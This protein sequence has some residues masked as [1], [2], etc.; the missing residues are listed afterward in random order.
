MD[1]GPFLVDARAIGTNPKGVG[2]VLTEVSRQLIRL[3]PDQYHFL[4]T[5]QG[6]PALRE[7]G[8]TR[9]HVLPRLPTSAWEQLVLPAAATAI[10]AAATYSHGECGAL[11][12]PPLLL[13]LTEDPAVRWA[14]DPP[15]HLR[16]RARRLYSRGFMKPSLK[17]AS[18]AVSTSSVR[19]QVS[20]RHG[21]S[22]DEIRVIP[23]GVD[24]NRFHPRDVSA[25]ER[26]FFH[27]ASGDPRDRTE[28]L[29]DA[30]AQLARLHADAPEL[31]V[32]GDLGAHG[33]RI[34]SHASRAAPGK[35]RFTGR[36]TDDDLSAAYGSCVAYVQLSSDEGFG[37]QPLEALASGATLIAAPEPSVQEVVGGAVALWVDP[38]V[39]Q[40]TE[41]LRRALDGS[42]GA[43][44][45][46]V[47][48]KRAE[49]FSW[50][51]T[52]LAIDGL[53]RSL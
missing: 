13:H 40:V 37:L 33:H 43:R 28:L 44:A 26:F 45:R 8:A 23:L 22:A 38:N 5:T 47:N 2:R 31:A 34:M 46:D 12:G 15:S 4:C 7:M 29:L 10:K 48:P 9:R 16:E 53:L 21:L 27:L 25:D 20:E 50:E 30:Y 3:D 41:A 35:V 32:G 11:W 42:I 39:E 19:Q 1:S 24:T 52:A 6:D 49:R 14:R 51:R 18:L 36:L 17:R